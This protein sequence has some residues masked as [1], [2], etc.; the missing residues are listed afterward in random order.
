MGSSLPVYLPR[1]S[2]AEWVPGRDS[3]GSAL[4][5]TP[6]PNGWVMIGAEAQTGHSTGHFEGDHL[7]VTDPAACSHGLT[8]SVWV[9][10]FSLSSTGR[11]Y[12]ISSGEHDS[13]SVGVSIYFYHKHVAAAVSDGFTYWKAM[14]DNELKLGIELINIFYL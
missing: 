6:N 5:V 14:A 8:V 1:A 4:R 11:Q 10:P 9:Q 2:L 3:K 12:V 13:H 7:C